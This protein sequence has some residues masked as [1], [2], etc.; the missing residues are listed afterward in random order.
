LEGFKYNMMKYSLLFVI[1]SLLSCDPVRNSVEILN[2][3]KL[4]LFV[5]GTSCYSKERCVLY[6]NIQFNSTHDQIN[7][8]LIHSGKTLVL[9]SWGWANCD[10][11]EIDIYDVKMID[12]LGW[13]DVCLKNLLYKTY[14]F[15]KD[16]LNGK[17]LS[18]E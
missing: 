8:Y 17:K 11:I 10:S 18:I 7:P 14:K 4:T 15:S 2:N 12:S 16:D 5:D 1:F 13:K 6:T 9:G 3:T